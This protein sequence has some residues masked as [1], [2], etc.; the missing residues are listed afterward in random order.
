MYI[1]ERVPITAKFAPDFE[2]AQHVYKYIADIKKK[3]VMDA[4]CVGL[5]IEARFS[6]VRTCETN[7]GNLVADL[8]RT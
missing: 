3:L 4:A 5:E 2:I 6:R 1:A 7:L 8:M